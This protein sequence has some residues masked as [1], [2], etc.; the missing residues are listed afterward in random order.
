VPESKHEQ[1]EEA[2][3]SRLASIV[4]DSGVNWWFTPDRVIRY[5]AFTEQCLD[6]SLTTVYVLSPDEE[7]DAE[8][9]TGTAATG[10]GIRAQAR[11]DLVLA[12]R[13][14]GSEHPFQAEAPLRATL[15]NRMA[16]DVKKKLREDITLGGGLARNLDFILTDRGAETHHPGWAIVAM[17]LLVTYWYQALVPGP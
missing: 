15:Q 12:T 8:A 13:Y 3:K 1:I 16:R 4:G 14:Q 7:E 5:P 11:L 10:G 6:T 9:S 17:R 2:I